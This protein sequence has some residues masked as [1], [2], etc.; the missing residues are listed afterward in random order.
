MK[1]R[2]IIENANS[3][4]ERV[5][6]HGKWR[7]SRGKKPSMSFVGIKNPEKVFKIVKKMIPIIK[8]C[9]EESKKELMHYRIR[10]VYYRCDSGTELLF[11]S[12]VQSKTSVKT[13]LIFTDLK[14]KEGDLISLCGTPYGYMERVW[15]NGV[16][17]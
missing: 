6:W 8:S 14:I 9:K 3:E 2:V 12:G 17:A 13:L 16:I 7:L 5:F 10:S 11:D 4:I 1:K 15:I